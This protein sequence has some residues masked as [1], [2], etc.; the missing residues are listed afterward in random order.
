MSP[1][2]RCKRH[3]CAYNQ[4]LEFAT[5][6]QVEVVTGKDGKVV[7]KQKVLYYKCEPVKQGKQCISKYKGLVPCK[8]GKCVCI[9]THLE[10]WIKTTGVNNKHYLAKNA[11]WERWV[12][13]NQYQANE[14]SNEYEQY[15]RRLYEYSEEADF[16]TTPPSQSAI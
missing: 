2:W 11:R 7:T 15:L 5:K 12:K 9:D 3:L 16:A 6:V 4:P 1:P 10:E 8:R 14:N 13:R